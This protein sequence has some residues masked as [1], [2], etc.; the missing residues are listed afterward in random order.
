M[1]DEYG[2]VFDMSK[3]LLY[4]IMRPIFLLNWDLG[5]PLVF[6]MPSVL[7]SFWLQKI[8]IDVRDIVL[9][10]VCTLEVF[11]GGQL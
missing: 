5:V 3:V 6:L 7:Q 4:L 10:I 11:K 1:G 9:I 8:I 2:W